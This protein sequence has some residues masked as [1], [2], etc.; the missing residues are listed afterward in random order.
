MQNASLPLH[1]LAVAKTA[2]VTS[3]TSALI[4]W[5]LCSLRAPAQFLPNLDEENTAEIGRLTSKIKANPK[6]AMLYVR[7]ANCYRDLCEEE[8][9]LKDYANAL[10]LDP[11]QK[12]ALRER[13]N[14]YASQKKYDN[15]LADYNRVLALYPDESDGY[16]SRSML[17]S[18][19]KRDDRA[20]VDLNRALKLRP[21]RKLARE[22][23]AGVLE[24]LCRYKEAIADYDYLIT[25]DAAHSVKWI[26]RAAACYLKAGNTKKALASYSQLIAINPHDEFAYLFRGKVYFQLKLYEKAIADYTSALDETVDEPHVILMERSK[27]YE[28]IGQHEKA[29]KDAARARL[30]VGRGGQASARSKR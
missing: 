20:L 19:L 13:A 10:A 29:A 25:I 4:A 3:V 12:R 27:A 30:P 26:Q 24:R 8:K 5:S 16:I 11:T 6:D 22:Y 1:T 17:Y 9:A 23:R 2:I 7:R 28:K 21:T 14:L 18:T 15:A